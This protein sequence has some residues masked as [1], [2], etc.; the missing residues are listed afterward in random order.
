MKQMVAENKSTN[1]GSK[2]VTSTPTTPKASTEKRTV[3]LKQSPVIEK[4]VGENVADPAKPA[5]ALQPM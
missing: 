4:I 3:E 5:K 2:S 1:S